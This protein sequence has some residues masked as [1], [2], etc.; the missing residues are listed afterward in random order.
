[1]IDIESVRFPSGR[2]V[3]NCRKDAKRLAREQG[4]SLHQA[5]DLIAKLNGSD[6]SWARSLEA[7]KAAAERQS[8]AKFGVTQPRAMTV[9]DIDAV[10][11][12]APMLTH[13]GWGANSH[14]IRSGESVGDAIRRGQEELRSA[15]EECN[16]AMLFL[17]HVVP[18]KTLN[19][20]AGS[21]YGLKHAAEGFLKAFPDAKNRNHHVS[22]GAFICAALHLGFDC[23][24]T[25]LTSVNVFFNFSSRSPVLE[26]RK[27]QGRRAH[28]NTYDPKHSRALELQR[29]F[30]MQNA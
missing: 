21:S 17:A 10:I 14:A 6:L 22:N 4:I 11:A 27:L 28:T 8:L 2:S 24:P 9:S 16:K 29:Q 20:R 13:F 15:L 18:R 3:G 23:R 1:M 25:T 30:G 19:P 12:R 7:M 26:W 5:Q